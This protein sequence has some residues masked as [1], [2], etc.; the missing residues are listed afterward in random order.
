MRLFLSVVCTMFLSI[1]P[2]EEYPE[3][4]NKIDTQDKKV[5]VAVYNPKPD[6]Y[7]DFPGVAP[8]AYSLI[9]REHEKKLKTHERLIPYA[10]DFP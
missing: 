9:I 10:P 3:K 4:D 2:M 5:T 7:Y 1:N 6:Y 8:I